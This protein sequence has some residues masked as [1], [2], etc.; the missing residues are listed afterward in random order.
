MIEESAANREHEWKKE[1]N[2]DWGFLERATRQVEHLDGY[3]WIIAGPDSFYNENPET[4]EFYVVDNEGYYMR[5]P[6]D[7]DGMQP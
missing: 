5:K 3:S 7:D 2:D 1:W 6:D 4:V